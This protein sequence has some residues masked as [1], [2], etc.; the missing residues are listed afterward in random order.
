MRDSDLSADATR[1][2]GAVVDETQDRHWL[3]LEKAPGAPLFEVGRPTWQ[4]VAP[5]LV[6]MHTRFAQPALQDDL[7][8]AHYLLR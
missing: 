3:F 6:Q 7:T 2:Y 5:G 1:C 4:R 8:T